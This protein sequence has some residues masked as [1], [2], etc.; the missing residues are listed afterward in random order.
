MSK[1]VVVR[2]DR[3]AQAYTVISESADGTTRLL[4]KAGIPHRLIGEQVAAATPVDAEAI[5]AALA[6]RSESSDVHPTLGVIPRKEQP[7]MASP[8]NLVGSNNGRGNRSQV[9]QMCADICKRA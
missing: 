8:A 9:R 6:P 2:S 4:R 5:R 1:I 3:G 7:L